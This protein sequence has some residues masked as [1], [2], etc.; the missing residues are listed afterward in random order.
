MSE[1]ERPDM[2]DWEDNINAL[3]D[4]E[5]NP[6]ATATLKAAATDDAILARAIIEAYQLQQAMANITVERAPASLR[7]KLRR[8]PGEQRSG[9]RPAY[10]Q[11]RWAMALAAIPLVILLI[12][13]AGPKEPTEAELVKARQDLAIAFATI[14]KVSNRTGREIESTLGGEM[15]DAVAGS[16]IR[17]IQQQN[18]LN[19]EKQA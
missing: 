16:V 11:P 12:N 15:N 10:L 8:I 14:E 4:G 3:L 18:I 13:L 17:I 7:R 19:K 5:L 6:E 1:H 2:Q 9:Q